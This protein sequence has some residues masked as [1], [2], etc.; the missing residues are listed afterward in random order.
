MQSYL[1]FSAL[2]KSAKL[3]LTDGGSIQEECAYL[4][5]PCLILRN[6]TE[7]PDGLGRNARLWG[8]EDSAAEEYLS[9]AESLVGAEAEQWPR[10]SAKIVDALMEHGGY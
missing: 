8:F 1:N 10:P 5:K 9:W 7:R 3:V 6:R 2:L 4:N